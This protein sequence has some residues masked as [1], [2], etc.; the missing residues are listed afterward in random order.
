MWENSITRV[1][2]RCLLYAVYCLELLM[3][4]SFSDQ[5]ASWLCVVIF[6]H[7]TQSFHKALIS[8]GTKMVGAATLCGNASLH[9][10]YGTD[11]VSTRTESQGMWN[12]SSP[13][14]WLAGAVFLQVRIKMCLAL[15]GYVSVSICQSQRHYR[16][17]SDTWASSK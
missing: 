8:N 14:W 2:G 1:H 11:G 5:L 7:H 13:S 6:D 10:H 3:T 17:V 4:L 15:F 16:R 9:S 12:R